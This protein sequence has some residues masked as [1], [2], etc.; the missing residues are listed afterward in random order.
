[1]T[2]AS[3]SL[4]IAL[5]AILLLLSVRFA[6]VNSELTGELDP[7]FNQA[8]VQVHKAELAGATASEV[9]NLVVL[10]NKALA[11]NEQALQ[12]AGPE[13]AQRQAQLLAQVDEI[14]GTVQFEATQLEVVSTQRTFTNEVLAYLSGGIAALLA[15]IAY[16]Y[17]ISL[18]HKY[19]V[20]RTFQMK[21][22]PK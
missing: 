21:V 1:M 16:A 11:L 13:D 18:W 17:G 12:L 15:T 9:A 19:R 5:I 6:N 22:I 10:L 2:V 8:I 3:R 20:K 14:L 7:R 4:T